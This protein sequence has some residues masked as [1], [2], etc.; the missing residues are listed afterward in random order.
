MTKLLGRRRVAQQ[1]GAF[2]S[3]QESTSTEYGA[4]VI[5][6]LP[7]SNLI[8]LSASLALGIGLTVLLLRRREFRIF[9]VFFLF[10]AAE[11]VAVAA[12]VAVISHYIA[13]FYVYWCSE[14]VVLP[15]SLLALHE[16]FHE[17]FAGLFRLWWFRLFYYGTILAVLAVA[18]RNAIQHPPVQAHAIISLVLDAGIAINFVRMGIIGLFVVFDRLLDMEY[19]RYA[20]GIV[21]GFGIS[22]VG[23]LLGFLA[24]SVSGTKL[25]F[26]ARKAPAVAYILGL[27]VW[28]ITFIT[29]QQ[30]EGEWKPPMSPEQ[31]LEEVQGY[32]RALRIRGTKR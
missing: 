6:P 13:Y 4:G 31:M 16:V 24:F 32:L 11:V 8:E 10:T 15:L 7:M 17:V 29:R 5:W 14:A 27:I 23:S 25:I 28:I 22:S 1:L 19:D 12:R 30:K 18:I 20:H 21:V 26:F 9:P 2:P 3:R